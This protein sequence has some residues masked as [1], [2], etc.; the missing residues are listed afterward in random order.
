MKEIDSV[1]EKEYMDDGS[2]IQLNL[3]INRLTKTA[4]FDFEG[5][6]I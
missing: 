1:R 5:T 3:T 2:T 6:S 4:I